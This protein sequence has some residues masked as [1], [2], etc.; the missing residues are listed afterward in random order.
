VLHRIHGAVTLLSKYERES[1]NWSQMDVKRKTYDIQTCTKYY[2]TYPTPTLIHLSHRFIPVRRNPQRRSLLTVS[3]PL[4]DLR[5]ITCDFRTSLREFLGP[6][7]NGCTQQ[8]LS[9]V[10]RKYLFMNILCTESFCPQKTHNRTLLF[11]ST[12]LKH[13]RHF[14]C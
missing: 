8:T 4:P 9:I 14:D 2:S 11:G 5:F 13:F 3:Q 6:V 1:V 12:H 10:S 7:V